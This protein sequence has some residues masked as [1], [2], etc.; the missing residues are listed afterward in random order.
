[1]ISQYTCVCKYFGRLFVVSLLSVGHTMSH[2]G[3][4]VAVAVQHSYQRRRIQA[5]FVAL[6]VYLGFHFTNS[7]VFRRVRIVAKSVC[8]LRRVRPSASVSVPPAGR[9]SVKFYVGKLY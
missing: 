4:S 3:G 9:I 6:L 7:H 2:C 1:M 8:Y 5:T